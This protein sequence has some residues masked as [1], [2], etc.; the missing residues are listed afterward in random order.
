M[1][2]SRVSHESALPIYLMNLNLFINQLIDIK[3][4]RP[5]RAMAS[6]PFDKLQGA[7]FLTP[8]SLEPKK[9]GIDF[10]S[11]MKAFYWTTKY[12]N[13]YQIY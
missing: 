1:I 13:T 2:Q 12:G 11:Q 10:P 8:T 5:L 6:C 4:F 9:Q 7:A 3:L